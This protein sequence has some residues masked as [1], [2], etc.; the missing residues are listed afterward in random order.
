[1]GI[2]VNSYKMTTPV[3][4]INEGGTLSNML[5]EQYGFI[6]EKIK[7]SNETYLSM[8]DLLKMNIQ[9]IDIHFCINNH[10]F[11]EKAHVNKYKENFFL[12]YE[13]INGV[14]KIKVLPLKMNPHIGKKGKKK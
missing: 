6:F 10:L 4:F 11:H 12:L 9:S 14:Q 2:Y 8:K 7:E 13:F 5:H 3:F 1:M